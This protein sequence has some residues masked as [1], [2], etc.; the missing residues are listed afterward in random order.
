MQD[1]VETREK[2]VEIFTYNMWKTRGNLVEN[3]T[4]SLVETRGIHAK[5][6]S[7][8]GGIHVEYIWKL[9]VN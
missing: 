5:Y 7:N 1:H 6:T 3:E 4:N 8:L 9:G 2:H